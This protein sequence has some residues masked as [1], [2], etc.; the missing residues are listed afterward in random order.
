MEHHRVAS[1]SRRP[2]T[3]WDHLLPIAPAGVVQTE[4]EEARRKEV[5]LSAATGYIQPGVIHQ[6]SCMACQAWRP[7]GTGSRWCQELPVASA[8]G[9]KGPHVIS[10]QASGQLTTHQ[11]Q[12]AS[13]GHGHVGVTGGLWGRDKET[14]MVTHAEAQRETRTEKQVCSEGIKDKTSEALYTWS[15]RT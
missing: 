14:E 10:E 12:E 5:M 1:G 9:A 6:S 8:Q 4:T 11:H 7:G 2:P 13:P 15:P 3:C